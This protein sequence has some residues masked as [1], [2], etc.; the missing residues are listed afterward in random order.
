MGV[1]RVIPCDFDRFYW[2]LRAV[3]DRLRNG[4]GSNFVTHNTAVLIVILSQA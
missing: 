2:F 3:L 4:T 1:L